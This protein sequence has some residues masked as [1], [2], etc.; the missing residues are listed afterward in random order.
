MDCILVSRCSSYRV[1]EH[2]GRLHSLELFAGHVSS[3]R[4]L[5]L[6]PFC[7][8]ASSLNVFCLSSLCAVPPCPVPVMLDVMLCLPLPSK[9]TYLHLPWYQVCL[10]PLPLS[11][12]TLFC[13]P[14]IC[15]CLPC[16][17]LYFHSLIFFSKVLPTLVCKVIPLSPYL[18]SLFQAL[19]VPIGA[20]NTPRSSGAGWR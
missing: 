2:A 20:W 6:S 15:H 10:Q 12:A 14:R 16:L 3:I 7:S 5:C 11:R 4:D 19:L 9:A 1:I 17:C 13:L 8:P 18:F